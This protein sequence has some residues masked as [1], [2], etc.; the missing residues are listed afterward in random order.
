MTELQRPHESYP[1][2]PVYGKALSGRPFEVDGVIF[3]HYRA[4]IMN[5]ISADP[6]SDAR[7]WSVSWKNGNPRGYCGHWPG[8]TDSDKRPVRK[9]KQE[10]ARDALE[11][12]RATA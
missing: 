6:I 12:L 8:I 7:V 1:A 2:H 3:Y 10:A 5:Y 4:G 11:G 9:T